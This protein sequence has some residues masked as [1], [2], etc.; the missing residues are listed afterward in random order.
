VTRQGHTPEG[1]KIRHLAW[2][3]DFGAALV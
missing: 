1:S 2:W 3:N